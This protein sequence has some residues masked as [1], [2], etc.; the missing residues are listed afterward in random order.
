[1]L[2]KNLKLAEVM[3]AAYE[4]YKD[5]SDSKKRAAVND[6]IGQLEV[7]PYL[8]LRD[9]KGVIFKVLA[10]LEENDRSPEEVNGQMEILFTLEVINQYTNIE[11]ESNFYEIFGDEFF[12]ALYMTGIMTK[13][14]EVCG[15]DVQKLHDMLIASVNWRDIFSLLESFGN[16]DMSHVDDLVKEVKTAKDSLQEDNL[17]LLK[18]IVNINQP[19]SENLNDLINASIVS[20]LDKVSDEELAKWH[21]KHDVFV[22]LDSILGEKSYET[23]T[24]E[25][26]D[27]FANNKELGDVTKEEVQSVYDY[28]KSKNQDA[29]NKLDY[30]IAE[31]NRVSIEKG[32]TAQMIKLLSKKKTLEKR[33]KKEEELLKLA[34]IVMSMDNN[35]IDEVS[36]ILSR[37][38]EDNKEEK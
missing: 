33:Y 36:E 24:Q 6:Y 16:I 17:D 22:D 23:I 32:M 3:L 5:L 31:E 20:S 30:A 9:K 8:S 28:L 34:D 25:I 18:R 15:R 1:M 10:L 38:K 21:E 7:I 14:E 27:Y 35:A 4:S 19:N 29:I 37:Y 11:V 13:I 12:D 26:T 2:E